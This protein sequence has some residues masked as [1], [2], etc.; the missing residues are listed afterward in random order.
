MKIDMKEDK[1][2]IMNTLKLGHNKCH[3]DYKNCRSM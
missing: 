1:N 2:Q 3:K